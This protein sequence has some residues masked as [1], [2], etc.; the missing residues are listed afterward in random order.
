MNI[1]RTTLSSK[2]VVHDKDYF[3]NLC[4]DAVLRLKGSTNLDMIKI[5]KKQGGTMHD[6][7]LAPGYILSKT[8]GVGQPKRIVNAKILVAN[9]PMDTDKIK[10]YGAKVKVDSMTK[11]AEIEA[12]EKDKMR[13]KCAKIVAHGCNC[14]INRQLIYNFPEQIFTTAGI[15]SIEHA[16]FDGIERLAAALG[17]EIVSTFDSPEKV[18]LGECDLVEEVMI[19]EDKMICFSGLKSGEACSIVLRGAGGH[20]LDETERSIHDALCVLSQTVQNVG[21]TYGGGCAEVLMATAVDKLGNETAGKRALAIKEFAQALRNMPMIIADNAGYDSTELVANLSAAHAAGDKTAGLDMENAKV[22]D[23]AA[24]GIVE[25]FKL[26][27]QVLLSASEA[28]EQI[29]R[30]DDII[31]CAP[32]QR[33]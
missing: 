20:V 1:A 32:R 24:I 16:D 21:T 11:T 27:R 28:A 29:L 19:G 30:V 26:K 7:Y 17:G 15:S 10:I 25:S 8:F 3:A 14:F 4:V 33:Q 31:K 12:A 2:V 13:G 9:T 22:G 5:I 18:T 23:M 6:S